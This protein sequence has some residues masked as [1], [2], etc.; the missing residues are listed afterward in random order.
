MIKKLNFNRI[1]LSSLQQQSTLGIE[2]GAEHDPY[3]VKLIYD[4]SKTSLPACVGL[5]LPE[6][7]VHVTGSLSEQDP[8]TEHPLLLGPC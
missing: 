5:F 7:W 2:E 4:W 1:F 6:Q 3:S 8:V